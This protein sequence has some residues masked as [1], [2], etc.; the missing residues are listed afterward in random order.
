MFY[1][2]QIYCSNHEVYQKFDNDYA[3]LN[4]AC[5]ALY[6]FD[7]KTGDYK[8]ITSLKRKFRNR[9]YNV[10]NTANGINPT[11]YPFYS[12]N[13]ET[14]F[15]RIVPSFKPKK[16]FAKY[17]NDRYNTTGLIGEF[18][19]KGKLINVHGS[20][21]NIYKHNHYLSFRDGCMMDRYADSV[22]IYAT[23]LSDQIHLKHIQRGEE[24]IFG[25]R[26]K[27]IDI[28]AENIPMVTSDEDLL[29]NKYSTLIESPFY[30][31]LNV[32]D[33]HIIRTYTIATEDTISVD[34]E[35]VKIR[36]KYLNGE[37]K[38]CLLPSMTEQKQRIFMLTNKAFFIQI[39]D[40][41]TLKLLY[42]DKLNIPFPLL[43]NAIDNRFY[44]TKLNSR[45]N[46]KCYIFKFMEN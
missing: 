33:N 1:L 40:K 10:V 20:Y 5:T 29:L 38:G 43:I 36:L 24:Q 7:G 26:G 16:G 44:F 32:T 3:F 45:D 14:F 21:D 37:I 8:S 42:D 9:K 28:N 13:T 23:Q 18:N 25:S 35:E 46:D 34:S 15:L 31:S 27:F 17:H 11:F 19:R 12:K 6:I 22:I 4:T 41:K 2:N 39:Y 30:W